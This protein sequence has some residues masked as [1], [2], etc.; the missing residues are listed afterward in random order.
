[1]IIIWFFVANAVIEDPERM[2]LTAAARTCFRDSGYRED[3]WDYTTIEDGIF[4]LRI[5]GEA[6]F[7]F[8]PVQLAFIELRRY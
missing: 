6:E 1:M 4:Y 7:C 8:C 5:T 2:S 3:W